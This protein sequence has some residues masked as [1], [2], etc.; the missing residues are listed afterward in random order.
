MIGKC[1]YYTKTLW[2][3]SLFFDCS[4]RLQYA[5][6]FLKIGEDITIEKILGALEKKKV[7]N[8]SN[9]AKNVK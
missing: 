1:S 4:Q 6:L 2:E 9:L 8:K 3:D 5:I 7:G